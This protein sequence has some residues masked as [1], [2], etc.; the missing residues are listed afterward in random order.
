MSGEKRNF[1]QA[2]AAWDD[3]PTRINLAKD[4]AKAILKQVLL[5]PDMDVMDFGC[6]TGLLTALLQPY[7]NSITG[8]DSSNGMLAALNSKITDRQWANVKT[9]PADPDNGD[10]LTG[11]YHLIV[12]NMT[13][14]HIKNIPL[15]L[16][17][18]HQVLVPG[19]NLF[20]ADLDLDDG[21]FHGD[22]TGVF[23]NGFDRTALR[24]LFIQAGFD[25]VYYIT[26]TAIEKPVENGE[27]RKF[28]VFLMA[29]KKSDR[30]V[31][32]DPSVR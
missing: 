10:N 21:K 29:G 22:N 16:D 12:S 15:L 23:H 27:L 31:G 25:D 11:I 7:V 24:Q 26:A 3:N 17:Q 5:T 28:P 2:A 6:G 4:V 13:L 20:I 19:G 14:H 8:I 9:Q 1:D 18:F 30:S 32:S